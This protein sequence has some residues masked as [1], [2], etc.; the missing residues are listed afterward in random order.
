MYLVKWTDILN[1]KIKIVIGIQ[2][3][4]E[5]INLNK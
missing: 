3:K 1:T 2:H 4:K 5:R